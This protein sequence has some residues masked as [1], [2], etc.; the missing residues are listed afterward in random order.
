MKM[1]LS[2]LVLSFALSCQACLG[3]PQLPKIPANTVSVTDHG[4]HG[5]AI[6]D[7]TKAIQKAIDIAAKKGGIV[8]IPEG[9]YLC[10]PLTLASRVELRIEK[11]A[12]LKLLPYSETFPSANGRYLNFISAKNCTD[13]KISG[14]G[15]I[16]GQGAPWWTAFTAKELALRR[17]QLI[18]LE[19]CERVA[20][21]NFTTLNPPNTHFALRLCQNVTMRGLTLRA[22][23][24][25]RNTDGINISGKNYLIANCDISTGDD[26]I[27][28]LTHSAK[29][30]ESPVCENFEVRDCTFGEGHGMS[31]GSHTGGGIRGLLVE[32]CTFDRT[33]AAIRMKSYRDNGG[34]VENLVYKNITVKGARYPLFIS[35]YY[36]KE[37]KKPSLD[38]GTSAPADTKPRWKNILIENLT[39]TDSQNSIILWGLP[40]I[41]IADVTIRNATFRAKKGAI[42]NNAERI[43]LYNI[44]LI[45]DTPPALHTYN[46]KIE[47]L[48]ETTE[49]T[50]LSTPK[51]ITH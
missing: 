36:P 19:S 4:A 22:P 15:V 29:D 5:D 14:E 45:C 49:T 47:G 10:G 8:T 21:E 24:N 39:V 11:G 41:P 43:A 33:T 6:T 35:S 16:D 50:I 1:R 32:N 26:N 23:G 42:I 17:P 37:P 3:A 18:A 7:N 44:R 30:W 25:S 12:T 40:E 27:V 2:L 46:A 20:L 9:V 48:P 13:I 31:I 34:L 38:K 28:I 51:A